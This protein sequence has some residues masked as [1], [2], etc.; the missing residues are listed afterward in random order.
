MKANNRFLILII[1]LSIFTLTSCGKKNEEQSNDN[2]INYYISYES[3]IIKE[4]IDVYLEKNADEKYTKEFREL[5]GEKQPS[6]EAVLYKYNLPAYN[7]DH[8]SNMT[9]EIINDDNYTLVKF[10]Q[11]YKYSDYKDSFI[12]NNCYENVGVKEDNSYIS[13]LLKDTFTCF[14]DLNI[15]INIGGSNLIKTSLEDNKLSITKLSDAKDI[16]VDISKY[17]MELSKVNF[18]S[19][20]IA[21]GIILAIFVIIILIALKKIE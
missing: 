16:A 9:K 1:F 13:L 19:I 14:R 21:I 20:Y 15:N 17:T 7:K 2:H 3:G 4:E 10:T 11:D 18:T 12:L 8:S 6:Q 5:Q